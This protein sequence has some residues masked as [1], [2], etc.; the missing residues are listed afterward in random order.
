MWFIAAVFF[1]Y[2]FLLRTVVGTFEHPITYDLKLNL[3]QFSIISS[4][5]YQLIYALMQIPAGIIVDRYG[6]KKSL[7]LAVSVCAAA[8]LGFSFSEHFGTAL[9]YRLMIGFGSSFGFIC[10][11]VIV[12][13]WLPLR[14]RAFFV[15]LSQFIG[16]VGPMISGG[17]L[18]YWS[19]VGTFNWRHLFIYLSIIGVAIAT[20][21]F[22]FVKNK[23]QSLD[24]VIVVEKPTDNVSQIKSLWYA[25]ILW[26]VF[27]SACVYFAIEYLSENA[28]KQ[29]L[30]F[31]NISAVNSSFMITLS[32]LG[33]ACGCP[34]IGFM[35]DYFY[36]RK[37]M[38]QICAVLVFVSLLLIVLFP[39]NIWLLRIGFFF[40][41][42]GVAGQTIGFAA[43][44][45]NTE[46]KYIGVALALNN[47]AM[48]F[49]MAINA[50]IVSYTIDALGGGPDDYQKAL[51]ILPAMGFLA[52]LISTFKIKETYCK[53]N[54]EP[55]IIHRV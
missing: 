11:L 6:L 17:P 30:S 25:Q 1:S 45:E 29:Y 21:A 3:V 44:A 20:L 37:R 53:S 26:I 9:L 23:E 48:M 43:V 41:G 42:V 5:A 13:E 54:R 10:I 49:V 38:M 51:L 16:T 22:I 4:V 8:M 19:E 52:I 7:T 2:E 27:Y 34:S 15:G 28:T 35:S 14:R 24:E 50:P 36:T 40:L 39:F 33:Y 55:T 46:K 31:H 32:W 18:T 12:Y 47:A